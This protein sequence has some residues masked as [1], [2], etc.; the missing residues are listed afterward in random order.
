MY[1]RTHALTH[2]HRLTVFF[3]V[4]RQ[5]TDENTK[6]EEGMNKHLRSVLQLSIHTLYCSTVFIVHR[7][8]TED[9]QRLHSENRSLQE[10]LNKLEAQNV[11]LEKVCN[12][13]K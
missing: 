13:L 3:S 7:T 6:K 5:L 12:I 2:T 1:A 4:I 9:K 10:K 8:L 11:I